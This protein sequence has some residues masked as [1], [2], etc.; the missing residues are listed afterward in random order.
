MQD[1]HMLNQQSNA[2]RHPPPPPDDGE[3]TGAVVLEARSATA[4]V[5]A[6]R[7]LLWGVDFESS[8]ELPV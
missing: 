3:T 6:F 2:L 7:V 8:V 4:K 5:G 1:T